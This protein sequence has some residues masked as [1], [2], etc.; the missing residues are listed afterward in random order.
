MDPS[1][2]S[3]I[4]SSESSGHPPVYGRKRK[5]ATR[6]SKKERT[7]SGGVSAPVNLLV[8]GNQDVDVASSMNVSSHYAIGNLDE[9]TDLG[10][11]SATQVHGKVLSIRTAKRD[12]LTRGEGEGQEGSSAKPARGD[13]PSDASHENQISGDKHEDDQVQNDSS[14]H[15]TEDGSSDKNQGHQGRNDEHQIGQIQGDVPSLEPNASNVVLG[16]R[17]YLDY[18]DEVITSTSTSL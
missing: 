15:I 16:S 2:D 1:D 17:F 14:R 3:Q 13:R 12:N 18:Y 8:P 10:D 4:G 5:T 7:R 9:K 11:I 6:G